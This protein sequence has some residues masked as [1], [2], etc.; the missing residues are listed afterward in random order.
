M[1]ITTDGG[2]EAKVGS[3]K[4][5]GK[6]SPLNCITVDCDFRMYDEQRL[7]LKRLEDAARDNYQADIRAMT[8]G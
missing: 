6:V 7:H 8:T 1:V 3:R 2:E 5:N 4:R